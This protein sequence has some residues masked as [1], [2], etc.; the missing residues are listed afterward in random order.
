MRIR[1]VEMDGVVLLELSLRVFAIALAIAFA[2]LSS[3]TRVS[4]SSS[5]SP[6]LPSEVGETLTAAC[7][8]RNPARALDHCACTAKASAFASGRVDVV[9]V[10]IVVVAAVDVV[11]GVVVSTSGDEA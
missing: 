1:V 10:G 4:I 7:P 11:A 5:G 9:A 8:F 6:A 3:S 2:F